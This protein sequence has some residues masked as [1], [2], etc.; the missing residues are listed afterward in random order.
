MER[1]KGIEPSSQAWEAR[2]LPLNH[3]RSAEYLLAEFILRRNLL[4]S[5]RFFKL[6]ALDGANDAAYAGEG[7]A[8][9]GSG[10]WLSST[11]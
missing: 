2:I 3:T 10:C 9:A 11:Q 5:R 8:R 7:S 1:V 6:G 4:L